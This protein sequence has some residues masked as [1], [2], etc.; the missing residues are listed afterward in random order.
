MLRQRLT[1]TEHAAQRTE[2]ALLS[3]HQRAGADQHALHSLQA[4]P[5][6]PLRQHLVSDHRSDAVQHVRATLNGRPLVVEDLGE[7]DLDAV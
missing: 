2:G 4:V 6:E 5:V 1:R 3:Q 7:P